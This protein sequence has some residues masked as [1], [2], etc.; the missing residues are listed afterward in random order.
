[1]EVER[2]FW[3]KSAGIVVGLGVL[4]LVGLLV[5]N[6]L[7]YR[8]GAIAALI[9]IF[10]VLMAIAYRSDRKKQRAYED[11]TPSS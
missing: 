4:G 9:I 3:W 7:V 11:E 5:L 10:G 6:R 2:S 1:M 8:F